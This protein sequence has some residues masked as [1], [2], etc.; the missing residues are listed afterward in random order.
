MASAFD[1]DVFDEDPFDVDSS[2]G[3]LERPGTPQIFAR[4]P[5]C[6]CN[7][8]TGTG[9]AGCECPCCPLGVWTEYTFTIDDI[10]TAL[11]PFN[12][13]DDYNGTWVLKYRGTRSHLDNTA[14]VWSTDER[15]DGLMCEGDVSLH[16][17]DTITDPNPERWLLYCVDGEW[18]LINAATTVAWSL[19]PSVVCP[20]TG[21][22][23]GTGSTSSEEFCIDGGELL[24]VFADL[25]ACCKWGTRSVYPTETHCLRLEP[26][27]EFIPC[28]F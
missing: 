26:T 28:G 14:C 16:P 19:Q 5:N 2:G 18:T 9:T 12:V 10:V 8:G 17:F 1:S 4:D 15:T 11:N 22:G 13:C 25:A 21:T 6:C 27:G 20:E 23:T 7:T 3:G 24:Y